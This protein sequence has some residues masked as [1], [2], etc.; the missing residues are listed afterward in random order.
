M[1]CHLAASNPVKDQALTSQRSG[2]SG[3]SA[4]IGARM[5]TMLLATLL[6][7]NGFADCAEDSALAVTF[8]DG[9]LKMIRTTDKAVEAWLR[10]QP[11]A[12][13]VLIDAYIAERDRGLAMDPE[14][15][16]GM[17]LILDAQDSPDDGF[18]PYRCESEPGLLQI[19][20]KDWPEFKLALRLIDTSEGRKIAGVGRVNL[21]ENERA[22]R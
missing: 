7:I 5:A 3:R 17:D 9:Y 13:P 14:L 4:G 1:R 22:G 12:A 15:G 20:G 10:S 2:R 8:M 6:P 21:S 18:L 11:L 16:W 19:Q